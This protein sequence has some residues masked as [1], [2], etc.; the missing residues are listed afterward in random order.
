MTCTLP[1]TIDSYS[2]SLFE[3][4]APPPTPAP[5][6]ITV[7]AGWVLEFQVVSSS[8]HPYSDAFHTNHF[9]AF[10]GK[11]LQSFVLRELLPEN[12]CSKRFS[13]KGNRALKA[14]WLLRAERR[15]TSKDRDEAQKN[16]GQAP[17]ESPYDGP[18]VDLNA[19]F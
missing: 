16:F 19:I 13:L 17:L 7:R 1:P 11:L 3:T 10:L 4:S 5:P 12:F 9:P 6:E 18:L 14:S 15:L 8:F 2:D